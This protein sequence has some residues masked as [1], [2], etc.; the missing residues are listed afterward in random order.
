MYVH[1]LCTVCIIRRLAIVFGSIRA[2]LCVLFSPVCFQ[3]CVAEAAASHTCS[4]PDRE[5]VLC[6]VGN[7]GTRCHPCRHA[8]TLDTFNENLL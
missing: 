5:W 8:A 2:L 7:V 6:I 4:S 3:R 1:T